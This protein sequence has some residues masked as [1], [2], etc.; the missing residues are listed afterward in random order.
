[1]TKLIS[2][3]LSDIIFIEEW[4]LIIYFRF[5]TLTLLKQK[6]KWNE[7]GMIVITE[8]KTGCNRTIFGEDAADTMKPHHAAKT[9]QKK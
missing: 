8:T 5:W 2:S 1:M 9:K 7:K 3:S 4:Y 6:I